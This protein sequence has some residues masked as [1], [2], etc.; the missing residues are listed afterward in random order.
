MQKTLTERVPLGDVIVE[1]VLEQELTDGS[2]SA[3]TVRIGKPVK[4][5]AYPDQDV[6]V[7]PCEIAGSGQPVKF[8]GGGVDSMQALLL[9]FRIITN[10]L[11]VLEQRHGQLSWLESP[12]LGFPEFG[13]PDQEHSPPAPNS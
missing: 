4:D 3:V 9:A 11:S 1:R 13:G 10:Y 7:C 8:V 6:F 12:N 5:P 2:K